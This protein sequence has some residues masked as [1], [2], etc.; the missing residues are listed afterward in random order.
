EEVDAAGQVVPGAPV[1][2]EDVDRQARDP[3]GVGRRHLLGRGLVRGL[4]VVVLPVGGGDAGRTLV[5]PVPDRPVL[6]GSVLA[7][8]VHAGSGGFGV[9]VV[10]GAVAGPVPGVGGVADGR[11]LD[12][13]VAVV[14]G[15]G[16]GDDRE[17]APGGALVVGREP[18][19]GPV[20]L[21]GAV[22]V[23]RLVVGGGAPG[24]GEQRHGGQQARHDGD[25][26]QDVG[27]AQQ[28]QDEQHGRGDDE[29]QATDDHERT[30]GS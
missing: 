2:D 22:V 26:E 29:Q 6:A 20:R 14:L 3:G 4:L 30:P 7:R 28:T 12:R 18:V 10:G 25:D 13:G 19:A 16:G 8:P 9:R 17:V 1:D 27:V 21:V 23:G 5:R 15:V 11:G 24:A